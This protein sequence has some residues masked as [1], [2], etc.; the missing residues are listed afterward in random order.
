VTKPRAHTFRAEIVR[1]SGGYWIE[2][3][4]RVS[5]ALG[6]HASG[7]HGRVPV[8]ALVEGG[9]EFHGTLMPRVANRHRLMLNHKARKGARSGKVTITVRALSERRAVE[10]P[11]DIAGALDEAQARAGWESLP[12]GK[13]EHILAWIEEAARETTRLKRIAVAVEKAEERREKLADKATRRIP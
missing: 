10:I 9:I 3:P 2:V 6:G 5:H 12:A 4:A 11:E 13:R 7:G 8:V 1:D